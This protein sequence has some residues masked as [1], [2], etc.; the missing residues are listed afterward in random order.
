VL[1][2]RG[3]SVRADPFWLSDAPVQIEVVSAGDGF[4]VQVTS[5]S[6]ANAREILARAQALPRAS[7]QPTAFNS[8]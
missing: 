7:S 2:A 8:R 5:D 4:R 6:T 1:Q 3:L